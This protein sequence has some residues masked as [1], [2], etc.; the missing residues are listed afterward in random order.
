GA[1]VRVLLGVLAHART[2]RSQRN[3]FARG[4]SAEFVGAAAPSVLG[5]VASAA[6]HGHAEARL[7]AVAQPEALLGEA[8]EAGGAGRIVRGVAAQGER[9]GARALDRDLLLAALH[10]GGA[11]PVAVRAEDAALVLVAV[12]LGFARRDALAVG[13]AGGEL[14]DAGG[15]RGR[16]RD[17]DG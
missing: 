11:A 3:A 10:G 5:R 7:D 2:A 9:A 13:Q 17:A 1:E 15:A 4:R 12:E 8:L 16:R 6:R 14:V